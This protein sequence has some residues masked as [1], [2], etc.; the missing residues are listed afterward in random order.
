[1]PDVV[2]EL[3]LIV[4]AIKKLGARGISEREV[5]QLTDNRYVIAPNRGRRRRSARKMRTRRLMVG[6]NDG[7]RALTLVVQ[8]TPE[9]TSWTVITG[10]NSTE[11]ERKMLGG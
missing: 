10:W 8:R 3:V 4:A 11:R 9:P 2:H 5:K 6:R 1:V 7:G